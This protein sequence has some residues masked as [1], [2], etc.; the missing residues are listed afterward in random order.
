MAGKHSISF[1]A[2]IAV[3]LLTQKVSNLVKE[4]VLGLKLLLLKD[5]F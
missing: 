1:Q 5:I 2:V 4:K 3:E